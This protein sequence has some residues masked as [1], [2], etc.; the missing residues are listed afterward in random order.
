MAVMQIAFCTG[1][2]YP[3]SSLRQIDS[4]ASEVLSALIVQVLR[5]V[6]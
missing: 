6:R 5:G 2:V 3:K 4:V 1:S